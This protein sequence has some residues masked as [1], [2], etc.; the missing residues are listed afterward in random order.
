MEGGLYRER[1]GEAPKAFQYIG[2]GQREYE[3][4]EQLDADFKS[5]LQ[6]GIVKEVNRLNNIYLSMLKLLIK[7]ENLEEKVEKIK[8]LLNVNPGDELNKI[9]IRDIKDD[10]SFNDS[11]FFIP[12]VQQLFKLTNKE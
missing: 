9:Y 10:E 3:S 2:Y 1:D 6:S 12:V 5:T 11:L 4:M 7:E 8:S